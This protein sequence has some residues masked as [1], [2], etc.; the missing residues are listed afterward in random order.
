[1]M[2]LRFSV[3]VLLV[4]SLLMSGCKKTDK[5]PAAEPAASGGSA[6]SAA[7]GTPPSGPPAPPTPKAEPAAQT[8]PAPAAANST[9]V[10]PAATLAALEL[11]KPA[12]APAKGMWSQATPI[13]D[14]DRFENYLEGSNLWMSVHF[15]DCNTPVVKASA[16][17]S[18]A[19]RGVFSFCF[20]QPTGKLKDYP[21][22]SP[23]DEVRAVK[24]GHVVVI[25]G[26]G[27]AGDDKLKAADLEAF[28]G[29]LDLASLAKL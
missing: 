1:M 20:D 22:F 27:L 16:K 6:G 24:V 19:D 12:G 11:P 10:V 7:P 4:T 8:P 28:L 3:S 15:L 21:M 17:L 29:S 23:S 14:G 9:S 26:I 13:V 5:A 18:A 25:A 2:F